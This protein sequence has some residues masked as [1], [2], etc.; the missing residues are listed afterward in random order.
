MNNIPLDEFQLIGPLKKKEFIKFD[1]DEL[2]I[3]GFND[4]YL[5]YDGFYEILNNNNFDFDKYININQNY[6][7]EPFIKYF[8]ENKEFSKSINIIKNRYDWLLN[9][10]QSEEDYEECAKILETKNTFLKGIEN[11]NNK[12]NSEY[13]K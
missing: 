12:Y 13:G 10:Y 9:F 7:L 2:N 1:N 6:Q 3:T 4:F 5:D 11:L 8:V